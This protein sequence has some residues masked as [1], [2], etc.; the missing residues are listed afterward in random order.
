VPCRT[1]KSRYPFLLLLPPS[2]SL[3]DWWKSQAKN[4]NT[5]TIGAICERPQPSKV[6]KKTPNKKGFS[7]NFCQKNRIGTIQI[8]TEKEALAKLNYWWR[9]AGF[10]K[11]TYD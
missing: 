1:G 8:R 9:S 5:T 7:G 3:F 10:V 2:A 11:G 6:G 4:S